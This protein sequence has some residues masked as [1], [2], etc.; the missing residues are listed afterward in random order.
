MNMESKLMRFGK[1]ALDIVVFIVLMFAILLLL[2]M[3]LSAVFERFGKAG[4]EKVL[5]AIL[6]ETLTLIA[7]FVAICVV[8]RFRHMPL[9]GLGLSLKDRS[10]DLLWGML[11]AVLIY[12]LGFG[13]SLLAGLV[14]V[15]GVAFHASSLLL[16]FMLFILVAVT[17]ELMIRGFVLGR[18]L[19]AGM[20][21]FWA[22]CISSLLFSLMHLSNPNFSFV[23]FFNLILAGI[24]LGMSYIYTRNLCFPI[25]LHL[26]WNWLQGP[27]LGY[28]VSG[29]RIADSLLSLRLSDDVLLNGGPFGFEG[30]LVCT[31]LMLV[32]TFVIQRRNS[33]HS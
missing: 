6:Q 27:V 31:I 25:A 7:T 15:T 28:E 23:P 29:T 3:P 4:E 5:V 19:D 8:F 32:G 18:L 11:A 2:S 24:M 22:L 10:M 17:E 16:S 14:E 13:V 26:F 9:S 33:Y 21:K 30:S 20:G 1:A 12:A